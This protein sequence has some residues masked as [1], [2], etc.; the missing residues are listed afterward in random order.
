[1]KL[2]GFDFKKVDAM[3][4]RELFCIE[5]LRSEVFVTEQGITLPELDDDD[6]AG[7]ASF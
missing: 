6:F 4:G 7:S 2:A 1:M 5:R 3:T